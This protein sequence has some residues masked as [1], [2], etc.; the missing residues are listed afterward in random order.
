MYK[1]A[2]IKIIEEKF[3]DMI[4]M[5]IMRLSIAAEKL[6]ETVILTG[7]VEKIKTKLVEF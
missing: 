2:D 1:V 5:T 3:I 7:N 4:A 6:E